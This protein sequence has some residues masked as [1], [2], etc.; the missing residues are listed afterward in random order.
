VWEE[1]I[2]ASKAVKQHAVDPTD[3]PLITEL[4]QKYAAAEKKKKAA[5]AERK[6]ASAEMEELKGV[7]KTEVLNLGL[8][9]GT[10][11]K[12]EGIGSFSFQTKKF[13]RLPK[14][15]REVFCRMLA[16]KGE[17]AL[18]T[19]GKTDLNDWCNDRVATEEDLPDYITFHEDE[20]IPRVTL[21]RKPA[22]E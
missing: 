2:V 4:M 21:A 16:A 15:D 5:E 17:H 7:L 8:G 11:L 3:N 6:T 20:F 9:K 10:K 22:D 13:W 1:D 19:I 12:V 14:A 18:L